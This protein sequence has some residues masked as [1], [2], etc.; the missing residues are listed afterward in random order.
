MGLCTQLKPNIQKTGLNYPEQKNKAE[1]DYLL[2][3]SGYSIF[4]DG[5][6]RGGWI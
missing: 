5:I 2:S 6:I 3:N 1:Q 4:G